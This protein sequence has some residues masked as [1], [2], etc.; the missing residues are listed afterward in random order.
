MIKEVNDKYE[1][2]FGPLLFINYGKALE[3]ITVLMIP[4]VFQFIYSYFR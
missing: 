1:I 3:N 4:L 2:H